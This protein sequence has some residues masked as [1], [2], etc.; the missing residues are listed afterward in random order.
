MPQRPL[1]RRST[2][3][4]GARGLHWLRAVSLVC[5]VIVAPSPATAAPDDRLDAV[6][7]LL[8]ERGLIPA[9]STQSAPSLGLV[10]PRR[11]DDQ[12]KA[13]SLIEVR[14]DELRPGD[15]VFFNTLRRTFSHVG[16]Y[17]GDGTFIH[18]PHT[19]ATVR[20]DDMRFAYWNKR[21]TGARRASA[22]ADLAPLADPASGR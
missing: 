13:D 18:S 12:A 8:L 11:A 7:R 6:S 4:F 17:I 16:I 20:V 14:R 2:C 15:L 3:G 5:A 19:G 10:L 1:L 9:E 21:F 22:S